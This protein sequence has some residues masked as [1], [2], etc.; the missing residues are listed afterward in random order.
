MRLLVFLL[1]VAVLVLGTLQ[2]SGLTELDDPALVRQ[3]Q[4]QL[5]SEY[6][7]KSADNF[8]LS[9]ENESLAK[10]LHR[11]A[12]LVTTNITLVSTQLSQGII[13]G[14][15]GTNVIVDASFLVENSSENPVKQQRYLKFTR[16]N[17]EGWQ[18][19]GYASGK[20]FYMNFLSLE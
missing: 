11:A 13:P 6:R 20:N 5:A 10:I 16:F 3:V 9:L 18:F 4:A 17:T 19:T 1:T 7:E 8:N 14:K 15:G 2:F 12:D